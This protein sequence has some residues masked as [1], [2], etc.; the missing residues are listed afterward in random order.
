MCYFCKFRNDAL[1][2][3]EHQ[4]LIK[5]V[6]MQIKGNDFSLRKLKDDKE[7]EKRINSTF[8]FLGQEVRM[9]GDIIQED[10]QI[11]RKNEIERL[12]K[13]NLEFKSCLK[14][15]KKERLVLFN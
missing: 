1:K 10:P 11:W 5:E 4:F 12:Q 7:F 2:Y 14:D 3:G 9:F 15:Y 13:D 6:E 8:N